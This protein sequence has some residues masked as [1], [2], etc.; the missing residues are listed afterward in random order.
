VLSHAR[1]LRQPRFNN[2]NDLLNTTRGKGFTLLEIVVVVF[3][4]G[5]V[6]SLVVITFKPNKGRELK[7]EA[8]RFMTLVSLATQ[9]SILLSKDFALQLTHDGYSFLTLEDQQWVTVDDKTFRERT[10]PKGDYMD[11]YLEGEKLEL[12][13]SENKDDEKENHPRIFLL[14]SG[15][16]TP[17]EVIF[18]SDDISD[19]YHVSGDISGKLSMEEQQ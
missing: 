7:T 15:E 13:S 1:I 12:D 3:I 10:L 8:D 6:L 17:F 11:V 2:C 4:I 5:I 14:S 9:E 16:M 18:Q 19:S